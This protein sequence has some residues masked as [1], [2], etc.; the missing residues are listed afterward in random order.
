MNSF[1]LDDIDYL[2]IIGKIRFSEY[3]ISYYEKYSKNMKRS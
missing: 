2:V 1:T 3:D